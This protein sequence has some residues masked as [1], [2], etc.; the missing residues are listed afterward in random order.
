LKV[1]KRKVAKVKWNWKKTTWKGIKSAA[2]V[3]VGIAVIAFLGAFDTPDELMD[4]G[5][6]KEF[7]ALIAMGVAFMISWARNYL[8]TNYPDLYRRLTPGK[9]GL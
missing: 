6:P 9:S 4:T 2:L 5:V 1:A 3:A 7:A 8:K